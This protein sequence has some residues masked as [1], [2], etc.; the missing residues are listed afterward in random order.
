MNG[1]QR[2]VVTA[3]ALAITGLGVSGCVRGGAADPD[4][5]FLDTRW[6]HIK[7]DTH[8][9]DDDDGR[10]GPHH[11]GGGKGHKR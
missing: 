5:K 3:V 8:M 10:T 2:L 9:F 1:I 6:S 4:R 11:N 7:Q